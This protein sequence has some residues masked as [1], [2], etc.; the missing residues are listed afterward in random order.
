MGRLVEETIIPPQ[1][2]AAHV[3]GLR[4]FHK[5]GA[6]ALLNQM[7]AR[8]SREDNP[9]RRQFDCEASARN[10]VYPPNLTAEILAADLSE[11]AAYDAV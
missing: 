5:S 10:K 8:H 7:G 11:K 9:S 1:H 3:A 6:G 2:R 4:R